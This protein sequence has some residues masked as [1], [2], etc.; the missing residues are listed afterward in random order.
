MEHVARFRIPRAIIDTNTLLHCTS[1]V[2][3]TKPSTLMCSILHN[4]QLEQK[5]TFGDRDHG[6]YVIPDA[7]AEDIKKAYRRLA[8]KHHPDN[9][10][11]DPHADKRFKEIAIA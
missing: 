3:I 11:D 2:S 9:N 1:G 7:P 10:P 5:E 4:C 6:Y 8:M